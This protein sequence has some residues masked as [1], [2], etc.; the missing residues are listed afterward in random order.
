MI[1]QNCGISSTR[2]L[3]M[4]RPTRVVRSSSVVAQIGFPSASMTNIKPSS[5]FSSSSMCEVKAS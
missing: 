4:M 5:F 3:R 2:I 1:F